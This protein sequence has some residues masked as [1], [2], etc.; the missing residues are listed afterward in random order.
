LPEVAQE[1]RTWLAK[2][3]DVEAVIW[4]GHTTNWREKR[5]RDFSRENAVLYLDEVHEDERLTRTFAGAREYVQNA[6]PSIQTEVRKRMREKGWADLKL[7]DV[8]FETNQGD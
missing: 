2:R 8:L 1:L 3:K 4:T 7:S 5:N 6:P